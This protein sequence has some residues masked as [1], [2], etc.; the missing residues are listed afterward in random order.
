MKRGLLLTLSV[1]GAIGALLGLAIG[2]T[3]V[4][5]SAAQPKLPAPIALDGD[6]SLRPWVRYPSWPIRDAAK[7]NTLAAIVS[8]PAPA[9]PRKVVGPIAGDAATGQRLVADRTRGGSCI[10]CH[11]M[12]P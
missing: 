7:F 12:G 4:F 6:A 3:G 11:V 10:A 2:P 8:P 1:A 5:D 9:E